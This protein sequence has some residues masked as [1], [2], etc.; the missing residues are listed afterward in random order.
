[1]SSAYNKFNIFT[2]NLT[3]GAHNF[4]SNVFKTML[5]NTAPIAANAV[6]ADLVEITAHNGYSA[7]G[8]ASA[9]TE[10]TTTG[11]VKEVAAVTTFTASG[12]TI[13]PFRYVVL[14]NFTQTSP[15]KPLVAWWDYGSSI[16]LNDTE[17]FTVN[18]DQTNG[19]FTL[20]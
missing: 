10:T 8:T 14:Y 3:D 18:Y 5:S 19:I 1:M 17:T 16:T 12:G 11:T 6:F 9:I 13:G 4:S 20:A 15:V 2:I 7:G